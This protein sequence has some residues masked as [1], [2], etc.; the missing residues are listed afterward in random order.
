MECYERTGASSWPEE[1]AASGPQGPTYI[2]TGAFAI[3]STRRR[4]AGLHAGCRRIR[5]IDAPTTG[6]TP[7]RSDAVGGGAV[8]PVGTTSTEISE[9]RSMPCRASRAA[10]TSAALDVSEKSAAARIARGGIMPVSAPSRDRGAKRRRH[11]A[12]RP[13]RMLLSPQQRRAGGTPGRVMFPSRRE[14][15]PGGTCNEFGQPPHRGR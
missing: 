6:P 11:V 5:R 15:F 7:E 8:H 4:A 2:S 1:K 14:N 3:E 10:S 12:A 9:R 13:A